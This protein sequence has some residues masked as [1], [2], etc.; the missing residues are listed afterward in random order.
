MT[1]AHNFQ[2]MGASIFPSQSFEV[3]L[4]KQAITADYGREVRLAVMQLPDDISKSLLA[5][6]GEPDAGLVASV[7]ASIIERELSLENIAA[8]IGLDTAYF[9]G[10]ASRRLDERGLSEGD[11]DWNDGPSI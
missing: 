2:P 6:Y 1:A 7:E 4:H 3:I 9:N 10:A 8:E 11:N 5:E